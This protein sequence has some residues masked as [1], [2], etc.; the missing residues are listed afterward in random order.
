[1]LR[2]AV[3][4][5]SGRNIMLDLETSDMSEITQTKRISIRC[6]KGNCGHY[7]KH[8]DSKCNKYSDRIDCSISRKNRRKVSSHSRRR[9]LMSSLSWS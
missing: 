8:S 4:A 6:G 5:Y 3:Q 2:L 1:M 9:Q 7:D